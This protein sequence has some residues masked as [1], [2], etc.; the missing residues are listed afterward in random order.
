M[1]SVVVLI[2]VVTSTKYRSTLWV[3]GPAPRAASGSGWPVKS[4]QPPSIK[5][6]FCAAFRQ[7]KPR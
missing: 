4:A 7:D 1:D 2:G 5:D 6:V 3:L